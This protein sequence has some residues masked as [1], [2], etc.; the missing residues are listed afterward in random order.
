[1]A[2]VAE[3]LETIGARVVVFNQ[4]AFADTSISFSV[5]SAGVTG[6][7]ML[8]SDRCALED[9]ASVYTRMMDDH[10][11]PEVTVEPEDSPVRNTCRTLHEDLWRWLDI[12]P[13][14]VLNRAFAMASNSSKPYQ[15]QV[16]RS[17]GFDIPETLVTNDPALALAF[18]AR[19]GRVVFKSTSSIRSIVNELDGRAL[20]RLEH[21]RWCPVQFQAFV[22]GVDVRVH[23]VGDEAYATRVSSAATDYR[24]GESRLDPMTL[25]DDVAERCIS[26]S[27]RLGLPFTG[28]DLRLASD[29]RVVC[30]EVNPSPAFSYYESHTGQPIANAVA[31]HLRDACV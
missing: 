20:E 31:R 7:L 3:A 10:L 8:G 5:S 22:E 14:R 18:R 16:I 21:I 9:I 6:T 26:L 2:M 29:G 19:H 4:R 24:Y 12:A 11:L 13:S 27:R 30:F 1:M 25:S 23:V 28:I 15:A 17:C